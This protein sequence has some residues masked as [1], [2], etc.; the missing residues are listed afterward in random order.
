MKDN[1]KRI[2]D[3]QAEIARHN[4]LYYQKADPEISDFEYDLLVR[5][6]HDLLGGGGAAVLSEVGNDLGEGSQTI[7]H[8][9]RMIS[10]DNAYDL[11]ELRAWWDRIS[12]ELGSRPA[13]CL[14]LKID[15]F[16]INLFFH[17]GQM[18]YAT[19]R[20]DGQV[21]EDVT[22]NFH[23]I[24]G[25]PH[26]ISH[27]ADIEIRGEIYISKKDF[28][29]MNE[30]RQQNGD[31][32]FANPRNAAAGSIKLKSSVDVAKRPLK[33]LFYTIGYAEDALP[34][35]SQGELLSF[36][37]GQG[38]P[39]EEHYCIE[40]SFDAVQSFCESMEAQ[41][42]NLDYEIDGVVVKV[43]DFSQQ[44][45]LGSTAKSP[46]WAIAYKFKPEEKETTLI[47]VEYQVGR[48]GAVTPVAILEP[49]YISGSTV[50]RA[51]LHNFDEIRRLDL[52]EGDSVLLIKS[53]EIIPKIL[54]A[55]PDK[56]K[57]GAQPI[58]FPT[59]CPVCGSPLYREE[60][61]AIDYC[62]S[63]VCPAQLRRG[64]VHFASREAMDITGLGSAM[65]DRLVDLGMLKR[66]SD[67]YRLDYAVIAALPRM[68]DKSAK[69]LEQAINESKQRNFDRSLYALGIR[70]VGLVTARNLALHFGTIEAIMQADLTE[71]SSVPEVGTK[72]ARV[73]LD[74]FSNPANIAEIKAL[75]SLGVS[76]SYRSVH[77]SAKLAGHT[78]LITGSLNHYGRKEMEELIISHGGKLLSG[79][80]PNLDYLIVG[81][82]AGSKLTKAQKL[83]SVKIIDEDGFLDMLEAE[84]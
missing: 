57:D 17:G 69:N 2:R 33:A 20:G 71:L 68:G 46:K 26:Q 37:N 65:V 74:Y 22:T 60:D 31:K 40:D 1:E 66:I 16:G 73:L 70:F 30:E 77:S 12:L 59:Q 50:S 62:S 64:I 72:I 25:I 11:D 4:D 5:E 14:E 67:I 82:K 41:R 56:R 18:M 80:S 24:K 9:Q 76:F 45:R 54:K 27:Q 63:A 52:Y 3:L 28:A 35:S 47:R 42:A 53:G 48:T 10:L 81:D 38:F 75:Q 29:L 15:G 19:T 6:L 39:V 61:A 23:T 8:K 44:K 55:F 78:F 83:G 58:S 13:L 21:G 32:L 7:A 79:V 49:V 34:F 84:G 36:L 51:T 43:N